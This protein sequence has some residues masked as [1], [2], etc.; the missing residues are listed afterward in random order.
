MLRAFVAV[1]A[2]EAESVALIVTLLVP[3]AVGVPE[4]TPVLAPSVSPAGNEPTRTDQA[5]APVPPLAV[6]LPLYAIPTVPAGKLDVVTV[7]V[8]GFT[9]MLIA[10]VADIGGF[11]ESVAFTVKLLVP[12][13]DGVPVITP[14]LEFRPRP[15]GNAPEE[16]LHVN[17]PAPPLA[18]RVV[19]G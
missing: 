4:I 10:L 2:G 11:A 13:D 14:V 5:I 6:R 16:M 19:E 17:V 15:A 18:V 9:V 1:C 8:A 3:A 12:R 7:K